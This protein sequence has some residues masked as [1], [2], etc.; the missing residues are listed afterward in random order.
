MF[1][2]AK[3]FYSMLS[4]LLLKY[5]TEKARNLVVIYFFISFTTFVYLFIFR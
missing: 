3:K 5:R 4:K 2:S 1:I